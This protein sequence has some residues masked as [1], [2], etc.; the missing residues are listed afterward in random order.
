MNINKNIR[1]TIMIVA[2]FAFLHLAG[3]ASSKSE[4]V[5]NN[6]VLDSLVAQRNF[7]IESQMAYPQLTSGLVSIANAGLLQPGSSA[8][9]ISLI[10]NPNYIIIK[11]D[12]ISGYLPYY[13]ERQM[14]AIPGDTN[15]GIEFENIAKEYS[16]EK[17]KKNSY[18]IKFKIQDKQNNTETYQVTLQLYP[19]MR[20]DIRVNSSHRFQIQYRGTISE[21]K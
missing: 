9:A 14:G 1:V 5:V 3:C 17:G 8:G 7:R 12:S 20:S 13:G 19:S 2:V 18:V 21:N 6:T 16:V 10:G 15:A 4:T 11:N